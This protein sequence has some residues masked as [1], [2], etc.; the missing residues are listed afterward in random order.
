MNYSPITGRA[1]Q[2]NTL[3]HGSRR[4]VVIL[5]M[6][7]I[8]K[9]FE[10][11]QRYM[12]THCYHYAL[13]LEALVQ[14]SLTANMGTTYGLARAY[15]KAYTGPEGIPP[16]PTSDMFEYGQAM[17]ERIATLWE[18]DVFGSPN[19]IICEAHRLPYQGTDAMLEIFYR[20]NRQLSTKENPSVIHD[21]PASR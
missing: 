10:D 1:L 8:H 18:D 6:G 15:E 3:S 11:T 9:R 16:S 20:D 12:A 5:P 2:K 13:H 4:I 17:V 21:S 14:L 7:D 19:L